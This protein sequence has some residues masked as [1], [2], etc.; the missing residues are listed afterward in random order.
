MYLIAGSRGAYFGHFQQLS[1]SSGVDFNHPVHYF[2][3]DGTMIVRNDLTNFCFE[4]LKYKFSITENTNLVL[5]WSMNK[6]QYPVKVYREYLNDDYTSTQ[7]VL[8]S[9]ATN[10]LRSTATKVSY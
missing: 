10:F 5:A 3:R 6:T 8:T 1:I 2:R 4:Y 9:F 7:R